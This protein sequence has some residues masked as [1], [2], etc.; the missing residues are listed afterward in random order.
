MAHERHQ[1]AHRR[2]GR[3]HRRAVAV[4]EVVEPDRRTPPLK[5]R[6]AQE[7]PEEQ[8][9]PSAALDFGAASQIGGVL[10]LV[11]IILALT[12]SVWEGLLLV[13]IG[14]AVFVGSPRARSSRRLAALDASRANGAPSAPD[15]A[16]Q[17]WRVAW[18]A[19]R[20]VRSSA[21][22]VRRRGP[23]RRPS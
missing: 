17:D 9:L 4:A 23:I 15:C 13:L 22:P 19:R 14:L 2:S 20:Q 21:G 18:G 10:V 7:A 1:R 3:D 12:F 5:G 8:W 11:G 6:G 16:G